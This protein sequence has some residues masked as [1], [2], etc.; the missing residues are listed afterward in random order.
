[1]TTDR[2]RRNQLKKATEDGL[3][4]GRAEGQAE[5]QIRSKQKLISVAKALLADGMSPEKVCSIT[6]LAKEDILD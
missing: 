6:G 1:M 3:R 4:D 2:D 5:E